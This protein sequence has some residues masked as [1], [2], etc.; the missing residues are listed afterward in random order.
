MIGRFQSSQAEDE[1]CID[2]SPYKVI[3]LQD[4]KLQ[5]ANGS[6]KEEVSLFG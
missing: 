4:V 6:L 1:P 5:N 3:S 2:T